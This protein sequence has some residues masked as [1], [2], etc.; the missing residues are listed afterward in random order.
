MSN[1]HFMVIWFPHRFYIN[2]VKK[3]CHKPRP[4]QSIIHKRQAL[5]PLRVLPEICCFRWV[6]LLKT[7][8]QSKKRLRASSLLIL[9]WINTSMKTQ[10]QCKIWSCKGVLYVN[11]SHVLHDSVSRGSRLWVGVCGFS[12]LCWCCIHEVYFNWIIYFFI[13][14]M[15]SIWHSSSVHFLRPCEL[16]FF[17]FWCD[18]NRRSLTFFL[19]RV[20][21]ERA[22]LK[23][24]ISHK[25]KYKR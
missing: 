15:F 24:Q 25:Q 11:R 18:L 5:V 3:P 14:L 6:T 13:V 21:E 8:S 2:A 9:L 10:E 1:F 12:V 17:F 20:L 4:L 7:D 23:C 22:E 16:F 19:S